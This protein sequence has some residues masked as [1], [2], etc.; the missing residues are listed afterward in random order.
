MGDNVDATNN[1]IAKIASGVLLT[2][3]AIFFCRQLS[4]M[5]E[6]GSHF[7]KWFPVLVFNVPT[8]LFYVGGFVLGLIIGSAS[9]LYA[10]KRSNE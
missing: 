5:P 9:V 8:D 4:G 1:V 7:S 3:F 6:F 2:F 10:K